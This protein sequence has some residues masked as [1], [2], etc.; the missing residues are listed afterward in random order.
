V[1]EGHF[2]NDENWITPERFKKAGY[3]INFIFLGLTNTAKSELRVFERA[4]LGGHNVP[5]H[6]IEKNF[7]GNLFQLNKRFTSMDSL[8]IIDTSEPSPQVLAIF[9]KGVFISG[10]NSSKLPEWFEEYLP[11]IFDKIAL[12]TKDPIFNND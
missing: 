9:K 1:Y 8:K 6:E 2:R 5:P 4:K 10:I 11:A 3:S 7:F 12:K